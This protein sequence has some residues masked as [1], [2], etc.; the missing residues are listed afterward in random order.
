MVF[1]NIKK[2]LKNICNNITQVGRGLDGLDDTCTEPRNI[3][4]SGGGGRNYGGESEFK[5]RG[6][7]SQKG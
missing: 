3:T 6:E 1:W 4:N 7:G 5:S 2:K